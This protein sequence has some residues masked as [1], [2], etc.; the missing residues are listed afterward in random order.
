MAISTGSHLTKESKGSALDQT[1]GAA[2]KEDSLKPTKTTQNP[3]TWYMGSDDDKSKPLQDPQ[4]QEQNN[5]DITTPKKGFNPDLSGPTSLDMNIDTDGHQTK[6]SKGSALGQTK[7]AAPKE[8]TLKPKETTKSSST[9][10]VDSDNDKP[11]PPQSPPTQKQSNGVIKT[12]KKGFNP[13]SSVS[14]GPNG[15][16]GTDTHRAQEGKDSTH[17]QAKGADSSIPNSLALEST[18]SDLPG[19]PINPQEKKGPIPT[20]ISTPI[21]ISTISDEAPEVA[22]VREFLALGGSGAPSRNR[23][24]QAFRLFSL[25]NNPR[26]QGDN[27]YILTRISE[28]EKE[29]IEQEKMAAYFVSTYDIKQANQ[30]LLKCEREIFS[31]PGSGPSLAS[32]YFEAKKSQTK[33]FEKR[34]LTDEEEGQY[35]IER[36][37][38]IRGESLSAEAESKRAWS[39]LTDDQKRFYEYLKPVTKNVMFQLGM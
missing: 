36:C 11:K 22:T 2:P 14:A 32:K 39:E 21:P 25:L 29:R 20:P 13:D 3:S 33:A 17:S 5:E 27:L 31:F 23:Q 38:T 7:G 37:L 10:Y 8:D 28:P 19:K 16:I 12:P 4:T 34:A 18:N 9:W 15:A 24:E 35:L 30:N 26:L 6:E 1:K